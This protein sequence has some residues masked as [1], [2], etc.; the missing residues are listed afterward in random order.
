MK[1]GDGII[2]AGTAV[3]AGIPEDI[4][5]LFTQ[6]I[7]ALVLWGLTKFADRLTNKKGK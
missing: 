3:S 6:A 4:M 7:T 1:Y 5:Q 2:V